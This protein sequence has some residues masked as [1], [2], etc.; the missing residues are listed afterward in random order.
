MRT[1]SRYWRILPPPQTAW[2]VGLLLAQGADGAV[3]DQTH[4]HEGYMRA[5]ASV[6]LAVLGLSPPMEPEVEERH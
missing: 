5:W 3:A 1:Q 2:V 4:P 6:Y